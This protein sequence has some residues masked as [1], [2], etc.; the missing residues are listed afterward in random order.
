MN[1]G[2]KLLLGEDPYI[3]VNV[4]RCMPDKRVW[5]AESVLLHALQLPS[6]R[7]PAVEYG[8]CGVAGHTRLV[9][10]SGIGDYGIQRG[11]CQVSIRM[12]QAEGAAC[13]LY[14][15]HSSVDPKD[16]L[17]DELVCKLRF[18]WAVKLQNGAPPSGPGRGGLT[19]PF[20]QEGE[21]VGAHVEEGVSLRL[22]VRLHDPFAELAAL[23]GG[24]SFRREDA[25]QQ[26]RGQG[27][28]EQEG[29]FLPMCPHG[30]S[31]A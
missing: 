31:V 3:S 18:Q 16:E 20:G 15:G 14:S 26:A 21:R 5:V 28:A 11:E 12:K 23:V 30:G 1:A 17:V 24:F 10:V 29:D 22:L 9:F 2:M 6:W 13:V 7:G 19:C 25:E 4:R 8:D 27:D